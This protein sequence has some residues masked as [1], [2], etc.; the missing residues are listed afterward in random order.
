MANAPQ[1]GHLLY[2]RD[3]QESDEPVFALVVRKK[4][5]STRE[6]W[7]DSFAT[8]DARIASIV[9]RNEQA[10]SL[11]RLRDRLKEL[12]VP[13]FSRRARPRPDPES[14]TWKRSS[15]LNII[16]YLSVIHVWCGKILEQLEERGRP[17]R[18]QESER[19]LA[20][21]AS[22]HLLH[23]VSTLR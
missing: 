17:F 5:R 12:H 8:L 16:V 7:N 11:R 2:E 6:R 1:L 13:A 15:T 14:S 21:D 4:R 10:V 19:P 9:V 23:I 22:S 20:S 18:F 3:T